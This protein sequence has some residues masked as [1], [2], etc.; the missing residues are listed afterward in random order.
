LAIDA[1]GHV[2]SPESGL[3]FMPLYQ[4]EGED[5]FFIVEQVK[6]NISV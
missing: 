2:L 4:S 3:I 6:A 5:G 1:S